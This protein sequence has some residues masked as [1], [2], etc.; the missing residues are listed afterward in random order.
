MWLLTP[1]H[2]LRAQAEAIAWSWRLYDQ[3]QAA[4]WYKQASD[5]SYLHGTLEL[6]EGSLVLTVPAALVWGLF[7]TLAEVGVTPPKRSDG[8]LLSQIEV[9]TRAEVQKLQEQGHNFSERGHFF[10]FQL[11]P[12]RN[13]P[14]NDPGGKQWWV[15]VHSP[16]LRALRRSYGLG[17]S[18]KNGFRLIFANRDKGVLSSG[19]SCKK[20]AATIRIT[21]QQKILRLPPRLLRPVERLGPVCRWLADF[22]WDIPTGQ[23]MPAWEQAQE[24]LQD[25]PLPLRPLEDYS[26]LL[27]LLAA[28]FGPNRVPDHGWKAWEGFACVAPYF[29]VLTPQLW[30]ILHGTDEWSRLAQALFAQSR[31]FLDDY[32][33]TIGPTPHQAS[34]LAIRLLKKYP[35]SSA[36]KKA[37]EDHGWPSD[38]AEG[39][40][41]T[42]LRQLHQAE[43]AGE[44][45]D[46]RIGTPESGLVSFAVR[47]GLPNPGE[48]HLAV[49]QPI[50]PY[51]Y[52]DFEGK[53]ES[54]YGAG[55]V[56]KLEETPALITR[57]G[58]GE[59][60]FTT[61]SGRYPRRFILKQ[62]SPKNWVLLNTTPTQKVPYE[63]IHFGS[64]PKEKVL[65][66]LLN[67]GPGAI[68]QPKIDG[69]AALARLNPQ[70][71]EVVSY[72]AS[73][74]PGHEDHPIIHTER[75][76][77]GRPIVKIPKSLLN[78]ILRGELYGIDTKTGLVIP[79][80]LLGALLN[81][82]VGRSLQ[83]Q[84]DKNIKLK[85]MA[86]DL[87]QLGKQL[88]RDVPYPQRLEKLKEVLKYLPE[89]FHLPE[90]ATTPEEAKQLWENIQSGKYPL[91]REGIVIHLP[92]GKPQKA[93]LRNEYDVYIRGFAP[94]KG[95]L[96]NQGIGSIRYSLTPDGPIVGEVG[97][98]LSDELR[99]QMHEDPDA[100]IGRV[101]RILAQEQF[102]SGAYRAPVLLGLHE[103]Y[104]L[105]ATEQVKNTNSTRKPSSRNS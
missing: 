41:V 18:P 17:P 101:A 5:K 52:K 45:E 34:C 81:A 97:S 85:F 103:D 2:P 46:W 14:C 102:P 8:R 91:T 65:D 11:G 44:H 88:L 55:L 19:P 36:D 10:P 92:E 7:D 99:Q 30:E 21:I 6:R 84:K 24:C 90:M 83:E 12:V 40:I 87:P 48:K 76:F 61:A 94:G 104:P 100:F 96:A 33:G 54:G 43:R 68:V 35:A 37:A 72:R 51:D 60:H 20:A 9:L 69:A 47:K 71:I 62:T 57:L 13:G 67:L 15:E 80:N 89:E 105:A 58:K 26:P 4:A 93:K 64:I 75:L 79:P 86:F 82:S 28:H 95:R 63:K 59:I 77:H 74:A 22:G 38:F 23:P 16:A 66:K 73:R 53:I 56:K 42:F 1:F 50:H 98:G 32:T 39:K 3:A 31:P 49:A 70:S 29:Q 27:S 78:T 25:Q